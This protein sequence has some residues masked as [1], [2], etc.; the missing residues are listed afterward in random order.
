MLNRYGLFDITKFLRE[1]DEPPPG[2]EGQAPEGEAPPPPEDPDE[3]IDA[4]RADNQAQDLASF[5]KTHADLIYRIA[6][7]N[8]PSDFGWETSLQTLQQKFEKS[9]NDEPLFAIF[10]PATSGL[11]GREHLSL[12]AS[13]Q[14]H[15][16]VSGNEIRF[17]SAGDASEFAEIAPSLR[18]DLEFEVSRANPSVVQFRAASETSNEDQ[19]TG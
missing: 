17:Q 14:H 4:A 2:G 18:N 8:D 12:I 16:R 9:G 1:Q 7:E 10:D 3:K 19:P 11:S 5:R 6:Q 15:G 13:M